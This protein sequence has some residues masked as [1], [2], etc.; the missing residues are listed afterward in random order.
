MESPSVDVPL[1]IDRCCS[2]KTKSYDTPSRAWEIIT[3]ASCVCKQNRKWSLQD[4][5]NVKFCV[6]RILSHIG[7][8]ATEFMVPKGCGW[9][10]HVFV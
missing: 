6:A 9:G 4:K 5:E 1:L 3:L 8:R 2:R 7:Y 10:I